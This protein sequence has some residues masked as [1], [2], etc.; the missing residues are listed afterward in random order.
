MIALYAVHDV[1]N[2][3]IVSGMKITCAKTI[4]ATSFV[5][6]PEI[7]KL[8]N[9]Y[10]FMIKIDTAFWVSALDHRKSFVHDQSNS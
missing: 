6:G 5:R 7:R 2:N 8:L 9:T 4:I 1:V 3:A 10:G